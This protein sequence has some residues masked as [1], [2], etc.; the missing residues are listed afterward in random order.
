MRNCK[1][2]VNIVLEFIVY[3]YTLYNILKKIINSFLK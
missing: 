2:I 3:E 1:K